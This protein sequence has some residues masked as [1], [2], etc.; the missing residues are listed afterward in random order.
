ML[1][2]TS[3]VSLD[4]G[5][6]ASGVRLRRAWLKAQRSALA[7]AGR[8]SDAVAALAAR[9][10]A[11]A[12]ARSRLAATRLAELDFAEARR[13]RAADRWWAAF[14][15]APLAMGK[16]STEGRFVA[17]N[18]ALSR[19]LGEPEKAIIGRRVSAFVYP[20]DLAETGP[21]RA[22]PGRRGRREVRLLCAGG[23][24]R[25]CELATS[26]IRG[27][28]G[29]P[30]YVLVSAVDITRH[31]RSQA[32]LRDLATRD[33]LSGLANRRSFDMELARHLRSCA[34][35]GP[36]GAL[37]VVDLD[38]FKQVNDSLGHQAGDRLVV[39]VAVTLR[40]HLRDDDVVAR[41]GGDEFA[42][43]LREGDRRAAEAV[44]R[45]LVLAVRDEVAAPSAGGVTVSVGVAPFEDRPGAPG[46]LGPVES[47]AP[48]ELAGW[49]RHFLAAAD[50]AMYQVKRSGRNGYAMA[51]RNEA[52]RLAKAHSAQSSVA[53]K[54]LRDGLEGPRAS[55]MAARS[56]AS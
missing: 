11:F 53:G 22:A 42:V 1:S 38:N 8:L 55:N 50:E 24:L 48:V 15:A 4:G 2:C 49:C 52:P 27:Q 16:V 51:G 40:R 47:L 28:D 6:R 35:E 25:W 7:L 3:V 45:K 36:R 5:A 37:L 12:E 18:G 44:A 10:G 17:V 29:R 31:K 23:R 9:L 19:L 32:A 21:G 41:L 34:E 33:P 46:N 54:A 56:A 30:E 20:D 14:E 13:A 26:L 39:E 43:I